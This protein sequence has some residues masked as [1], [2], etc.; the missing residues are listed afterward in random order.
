M[1]TETDPS[2]P[3]AAAAQ[4]PPI[5]KYLFEG[6]VAR[7]FNPAQAAALVGN[8]K[9]ESEWHTQ[10]NNPGEGANGLIQ[11]RDSPDGGH[12][13]TDL[14]NFAAAQDKPWTSPD[15]QMDFVVHEMRGSEAANSRAFL[16]ATDV[17]S[18]NAALHHYIRY[19]DNSEPTR[20]Q[21]AQ[22]IA[23]GD[24]TSAPVSRTTFPASPGG[25]FSSLEGGYGYSLDPAYLQRIQHQPTF[26]ESVFNEAQPQ[27]QAT[28]AAVGAPAAAGPAAKPKIPPLV[29]QIQRPQPQALPAPVA[30]PLQ[31]TPMMQ[32]YLAML[33]PKQ[34]LID[35]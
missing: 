30:P 25:R 20:L 24:F 2:A 34:G 31:A 27:Q 13:F 4:D 22:R 8:M 21:Y 5:A 6:L 23:G 28:P 9:Q 10:A 15:V 16:A 29:P 14:L 19:G 18:A 3:P 33:Q 7:G 32:R 35:G 11:W 17:A 1:A 26:L 12:R